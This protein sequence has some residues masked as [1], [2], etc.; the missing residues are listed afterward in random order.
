MKIDV[1]DLSFVP[2]RFIR[3]SAEFAPSVEAL[4]ITKNDCLALQMFAYLSVLNLSD[5]PG[6]TPTVAARHQP[7]RRA[8]SPDNSSMLAAPTIT[9]A[10]ASHLF[11]E[12]FYA[13]FDV[14]PVG[15]GV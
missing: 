3:Q 10:F 12:K 8:T 1:P 13:N 15:S 2:E 4:V 11:K 9:S 14:Q 6:I 5:L 7:N